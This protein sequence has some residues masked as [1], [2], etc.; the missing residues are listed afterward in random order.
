MLQKTACWYLYLYRNGKRKKSGY[1]KK[2][3][4]HLQYFLFLFYSMQFILFLKGYYDVGFFTLKHLF[5]SH[6][7]AYMHIHNI[8]FIC[9]YYLRN[10][11]NL[12]YW[13]VPWL[14]Q[15]WI[16]KIS[17]G[18]FVFLLLKH[19][20]HTQAFQWIIWFY[21]IEIWYTYTK[22]IHL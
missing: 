4:V 6:I 11:M 16:T 5:H 15:A 14:F 18:Y 17:E 9:I 13:T 12:Q 21:L 3:P 2:H 22:N 7:I 20:F 10:L 19:I 8:L 1:Q